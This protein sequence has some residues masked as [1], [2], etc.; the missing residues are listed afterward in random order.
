MPYGVAIEPP[1]ISYTY[2]SIMV[3]D[4]LLKSKTFTYKE[5]F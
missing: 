4:I 2:Y 3:A 1:D 5:H